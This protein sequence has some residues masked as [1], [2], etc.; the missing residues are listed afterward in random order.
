MI[1]SQG[2]TTLPDALRNVPG[3]ATR[4]PRAER[5]EQLFYLRGFPAGGDLFIDGMRDIGE[6]NRD[7][8]DVESV[9]VLKGPSALMFG[10]GSHRRR[11]QPDVT[12]CRACSV[13]TKSAHARL[14]RAKA[15]DGR[16]NVQTGDTSAF[17][18]IATGRGLGQLPLSAGRRGKS[19]SRR[20]SHRHRHA[21]P[22]S[23]FRY[24]LPEDEGR[25][26][27][28]PA[29]AVH[30][31]DGVPGLCPVSPRTTTGSRTTTSPI[32]RRTCDRADRTSVQRRSSACATR[33]AGPTTSASWKRR[34][35]PCARPMSTALPLL[36]RPRS[37]C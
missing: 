35:P 22:N 10:R 29:D 4:R 20:A 21:L 23:R 6:Y 37:S 7:L 30:N 11:H 8:F 31:G 18:L 3:I 15:A 34:S 9:E 17:R 13:A 14:L 36:H 26:R 24:Y 27:L 12:R 19:A 5:S 25:H 1:R 28:R 33:C 32:T 2:A 16:P